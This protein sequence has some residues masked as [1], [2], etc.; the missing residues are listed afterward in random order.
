MLVLFYIAIILIPILGYFVYKNIRKNAD[1][2]TTLY[3]YFLIAITLISLGLFAIAWGMSSDDYYTAI[4]I[5]DGGYTPMATKHLTTLAVFLALSVWSIF[6]LWLK[7]ERLSPILFVLAILFL[8]YGFVISIG[9]LIQFGSNTEQHGADYVMSLL[10]FCYLLISFSLFVK[11][12]AK[13]QIIAK[14]RVYKNRAL[15][16][17][18]GILAKSNHLSLW[19]I[20]LFIPVFIVIISI[21][22]L[23]GQDFNSITKVL[24]ETTTWTFSQQTH[25]PFLEHKGHYL[26]TV[27]VCGDPKVVKPL[28]LGKRHGHEIIVNR[29]LLIANA[30][31]E[32]IQESTPR[33]HKIIRNAYD[34]YGYPLSKK[35]TSA[36]SSNLVYRLMKPLEYLFLVVLYLF[37]VKPEEKINKQYAI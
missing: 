33:L 15:N 24:T 14:D 4:D 21:L 18:N 16:Y 8:I 22:M 28:R 7:A 13:A 31:E 26:C 27:A 20:A 2:T 32:L 29:Q 6:A 17:L 35:I 9:L 34:K 23:F 36:K 11:I 37:V 1:N 30:F 3:E 12:S 10:P 5:V 25:P 19:M